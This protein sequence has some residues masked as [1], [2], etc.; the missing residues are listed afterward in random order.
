VLVCPQGGDLPDRSK[1]GSFHHSKSGH[2]RL[3]PLEEP[4]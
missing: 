2:V 4:T 3:F 1:T